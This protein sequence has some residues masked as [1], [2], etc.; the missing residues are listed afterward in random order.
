MRPPT[1][2]VG[3]PA[4]GGWCRR[5]IAGVAGTVDVHDGLFEDD[6]PRLLASRCPGCGRHH[7]PRQDTCPYCAA[8]GPVP[9]SSPGAG[10]LWAWTAVTHR[11][12]RLPRRRP[13]RLRGG[14]AARGAAGDDPADRGRPR[15]SVGGS[16][17][18]TWCVVPCAPTTTGAR[19]SPTPS[20]PRRRVVSDVEV[21]GVGIHPFGR[22]ETRPSPTWAWPPSAPR[23]AEAGIGQ[24]GFQAAFCATAYG[25]VASGH[26]VLGAPGHDRACPSSTS[27]RGAPAGAPPSCWRPA[28]SGPAQYDTVLV[29]GLEKMPK[30]MIRSS[31]F[32]PVAGGGRPRRHPR[33]LRPAGP[34]ADGGLGRDQGPPGRRWW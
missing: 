3:R 21:A 34:A 24:G 31:F 17:H 27:R 28:P 29:F 20:R 23:L 13:L 16:A 11:P 5:Y 6:P 19:S 15:P 12:A 33:L 8:A 25:G 30:G 10:R 22:F 4:V 26:K 18:A 32:A 7:F 9:S 2:R 1:G 14:G